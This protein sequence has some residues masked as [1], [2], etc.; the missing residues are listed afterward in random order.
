MDTKAPTEYSNPTARELATL[1]YSG[2]EVLKALK[3]RAHAPDREK[4]P[5]TWTISEAAELVGRSKNSLISA[6]GTLENLPAIKDENT[7]RRHYQMPDILRLMEHFGTRPKLNKMRIITSMAYKGGVGKTYTT[8][9]LAH[10]FARRGY[11]TAVVDCDP[12]ATCTQT[13]MGVIPDEDI[14]VTQTLAP[15]FWGDAKYLEPD[16]LLPTNWANLS[17]IPA[18]LGLL[19]ADYEARAEGLSVEIFR[20]A[21][22]NLEDELDIVIVDTPPTLNYLSICPIDASDMLVIPITPRHADLSSTISYLDMIARMAEN[23]FNIPLL[24]MAINMVSQEKKTKVRVDEEESDEWK[25]IRLLRA[26]YGERILEGEMLTST[27]V[28]RLSA[29]YRTLYESTVHDKTWR[30]AMR[31]P[32]TIARQIEELL[33]IYDKEDAA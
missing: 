10:Y 28:Q 20:E 18:N 15:I 12:Q 16:D 4:Q 26:I 24:R 7:G 29:E 21:F 13:I 23:G 5:M 27:T 31:G 11:R 3:D 14:Q 8:T 30:R 6:E 9:L 22:Q 33:Q 1:A 19:D 25:F 17:I 2:R 32:D